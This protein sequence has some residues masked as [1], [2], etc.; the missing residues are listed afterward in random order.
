[1]PLWLPT[2]ISIF[3][4]ILII[5]S[6][7]SFLFWKYTQNR[8]FLKASVAWAANF[9]NFAIHGA[10][11]DHSTLT[12]IGHSFYFITACSLGAILCDVIDIQ[13]NKK[14][15]FITGLLTLSVSL[16]LFQST[17]SYMLSALVLDL[18]I[19]FPLLHYSLKTLI[20]KDSPVLAKALAVLLIINGLHFLDY[21]FLHDSPIG[22]VVGFSLAFLLSILISIL[23]PSLILQISSRR[24]TIE[25]EALVQE[26]TV[27]LKE[28]TQ[29]LENLNQDNAALV[30][31]VSHD[32]STP[33][34]IANYSV[35]K[36]ISPKSGLQL[37]NDPDL[38]KIQ[39]NLRA[40]GEILKKV[41]DFHS[42]KLGKLEPQLHPYEVGS[43]ISEALQL[44]QPLSDQK[45]VQLLFAIKDQSNKI[46]LMDP[47]L[48][49][50][51]IL[52]NLLS[53]AIKFSE[54]GQTIE[55]QLYRQDDD[56]IIEVKNQGR[57]ID[58]NKISEIFNFNKPTTTKG[59]SSE[60]GSGLGLPTV[61]LITEKM[62]G[63]ISVISDLGTTFL[64]RFKSVNS[65]H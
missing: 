51:Q 20:K 16:F 54:P 59:T 56:I 14:I 32:I 43:Q 6:V 21:P 55:V 29:E 10:A 60:V 4:I 62:G 64:L 11:Q 24:Y 36:L 39:K 42:F 13:F 1:M 9:I 48:F 49:K 8:L 53:N 12:L 30:S 40:V 61:K 63:Q 23:L 28:R 52:G 37:S 25:L 26:R 19:A 46:I 44:Y 5:D 35:S 2:L 34:M 31:I 15:F 57:G 38:I 3:T 41:K 58:K 47:V 45:N 7:G 65:N 50:N 18:F 22:S 33:I 27:K 17:H